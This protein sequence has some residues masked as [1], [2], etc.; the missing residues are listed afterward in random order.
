MID[1][2][3]QRGLSKRITD[4]TSDNRRLLFDAKLGNQE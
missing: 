2:D 1:V 4:V 3:R